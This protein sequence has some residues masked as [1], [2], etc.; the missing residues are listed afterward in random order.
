MNAKP[1][2]AAKRRAKAAKIKPLLAIKRVG[3]MTFVRIG[4]LVVSFCLSF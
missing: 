3:G 1:T 2:K 4:P